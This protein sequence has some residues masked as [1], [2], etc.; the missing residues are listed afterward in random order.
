MR[1]KVKCL[2]VVVTVTLWLGNLWGC[3]AP[4]QEQNYKVTTPDSEPLD[5]RDSR[6]EAPAQS[7][8]VTAQ[9][10][11]RPAEAPKAA[12]VT[13]TD[14]TKPAPAEQPAAQPAAHDAPKPAKPAARIALNGEVETQPSLK[15]LDRSHWPRIRAG[16][17]S[18][19]S[20]HMPLYFRDC[21]IERNDPVVHFS[22]SVD[23][24]MAAALAN[25]QDRGWDQHSAMVLLADTTKFYVDV[26]LAPFRM[27]FE[28][29]WQWQTAP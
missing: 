28:P 15:G 7:V 14:D 18:G 23:D 20:R 5:R 6:A 10:A 26:A 2:T 25:A 29:P 27:I 16:V 4:G 22:D 12:D 3:A 1:Y 11:P 13:Q 17:S 8:E 24:R 21:P 9:E 19:Q